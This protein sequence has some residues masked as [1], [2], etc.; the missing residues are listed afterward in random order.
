MTKRELVISVLETMGYKPTVDNDG[1]VMLR[2]QMKT[3]YVLG[4]QQEESTYLVV[5]LPQF[6]EM[7]DGEEIKTLTVC[8]KLTRDVM[9]AKLYI[10]KTLKDVTA[11]C[12]FYYCDE[13]CLCSQ[14]EHAL[15]II[16]QVR[17]TFHKAMR[18]FD[19]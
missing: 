14:L 3:V 18:E 17:S 10:D 16:G 7:N 13:E 8:N 19:E 11:S 2:Y 5:M 6:Y 4:T 15:D 1:D 12:E 9:L